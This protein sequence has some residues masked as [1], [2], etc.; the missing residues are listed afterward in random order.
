MAKVGIFY[1]TST[2]TCEDIAN[3]IA[4]LIPGSEVKN[5]ADTDV[6]SDFAAYDVLLLGSATW[7]DGDLQDDWFRPAET[8]PSLNLSGKTVALFACGDCLGFGATFCGAL[9]EL[10]KLVKNTGC[11]LIGKV[12][13]DGY[14]FDASSGVID[15]KFIGLPID[16]VNEIDKTDGRIE[17]WVKSLAL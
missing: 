10:Y 4:E 9:G 17:S 7:G 11:K 5:I 2:G 12:S 16:E 3:R 15:G 14:R 8:I 13:T 6:A 1:G